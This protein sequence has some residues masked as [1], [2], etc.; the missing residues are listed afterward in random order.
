MINL[1]N[2]FKSELKVI[3]QALKLM[4][5]ENC[6]LIYFD[7]RRNEYA[8]LTES[9]HYMSEPTLGVQ[10]LAVSHVGYYSKF[11]DHRTDYKKIS[12]GLIEGLH[13]IDSGM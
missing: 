4:K 1:K 3:E 10:D 9:Q 2:F 12:E 11:C 13:E 5:P 7:D 8:L 6:V